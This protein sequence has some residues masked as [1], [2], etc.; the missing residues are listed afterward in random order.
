MTEK[1]KQHKIL[2]VDDEIELLRAHILFLNERGY[3]VTPV[4]NGE[5]AVGMIR[6]GRFDL[7]LLDEF[8]PGMSGLET[9]E[10]IKENRPN[11]PVIM[12]TKSEEESLVDEAIGR[13]MDDFL[14]KPVNPVQVLSA[15]RRL[16]DRHSIQSLQLTRDYVE[17]FRKNAM[18]RSDR[19]T[20]Q[21]WIQIH[22]NLSEW[23]V[24]IDQFPEEGLRQT[25]NDQRRES[26]VEFAKFI[27]KNYPGWIAGEE[28]PV[29]ST[30]VVSRFL[31]PELERSP[32]VCFIILDC[33][34]VDQWLTIE[35]LL[36]PYFAMERHN[37]YAILPTATPYARNAIF[38][39]LLP[40]QIH[41]KFPKYWQ[42]V[43]GDERSKN[44]HERQLMDKQLEQL[45]INLSPQPKYVKIY[46]VEEANNVRRLAR[47]YASQRLVSLVFNFMDML[48]HGRSESEL[49]QEIAPDES[50]FRSLTKSW[51]AHSSLFDTLKLLAVQGIT[52]VI[53]TDHGSVLGTRATVAYGDRQTSTNLRYKFGNNLNCDT[54][55]ALVVRNPEV[56]GLPSDS[57]N[58]NYILAEEDFYFVYPTKYHEYE[59]QY[60]G[61]FQHGGISL[62]EM[63]VPCTVLTAK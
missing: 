33:M 56:F 51:F 21:D 9:L 25:H 27:E 15:C 6:D 23:D 39:G 17:D 11:L 28:G 31:V 20:W 26:N 43:T 62:E 46:N 19:P 63:I 40:I 24:L 54:R 8:M 16:L 37:Y 36:E 12:I 14:I 61:S 60:K 49:L 45:G 53:T 41:K 13:R 42:E 38:A 57:L 18:M 1:T 2:W 22:T 58:K 3:Q 34:R 55:H 10:A 30:N 29:L 32:S 44:R 4:G 50:A 59:R 7:V 5:D 47:G 52:V 35:P 48:A